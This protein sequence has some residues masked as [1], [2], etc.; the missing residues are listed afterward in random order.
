MKG[1][2]DI[3]SQEKHDLLKGW[4]GLIT[5]FKHLKSCYPEDFFWGLWSEVRARIWKVMGKILHRKGP[6]TMLE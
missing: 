4:E 3:Y 5:I 6:S 2:R 1:T